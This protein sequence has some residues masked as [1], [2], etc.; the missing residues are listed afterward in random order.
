MP[1]FLIEILPYLATILVAFFSYKGK[2]A[3]NITVNKDG[4]ET[5]QKSSGSG[6]NFFQLIAVFAIAWYVKKSWLESIKSSLEENIE[7]DK[8]ALQARGLYEA[9]NPS[10]FE[11]TIKVD[12]T[13]EAAVLEIGKTIKNFG[14]VKE[15]YKILFPERSLV[16]DLHSELSSSDE[17]TFYASFGTGN[18]NKV[19]VY[20]SYNVV[21]LGKGA[22]RF[23]YTNEIN[24]DGGWKNG[25][26]LPAGTVLGTFKKNFMHVQ[27]ET[28]KNL[29]WIEIAWSKY[30]GAFDYLG[31]VL[32]SEVKLVGV[33]K[34]FG[35]Q[36]FGKPETFKL[37]N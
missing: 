20:G 35:F 16:N 9:F 1:L 7:T 10:G 32:K 34:T 23:E 4:S 19:P 30:F 24:I 26:L 14:L 36:D 12:G 21:A 22:S 28:G 15:K 5:V 29:A 2:Q 6:I 33:P 18:T 11:T 31:F 8:E 37:M 13:D 3:E 25:E 17:A 27:K